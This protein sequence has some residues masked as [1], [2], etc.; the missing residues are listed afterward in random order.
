VSGPQPEQRNTLPRLGSQLSRLGVVAVLATLIGA[1][2]ATVENG[3]PGDRASATLSTQSANPTLSPFTT[4]PPPNSTGSPGD[5]T[6]N[7]PTGGAAGLAALGVAAESGQVVAITDGDTIKV[8]TKRGLLDVRVL[9]IDTPEVYFG[10]ECWGPE[11]SR[12]ARAIL[13]GKQVELRADLT[14]DRTDAYD[15]ALRYVILPNGDNYSVLAAE[16]GAARSYVYDAPVQAHPQILA[17]EHRARAADRGLWGG[18]NGQHRMAEPHSHPEPE[19]PAPEPQPAA[20]ANC[21]PGYDPCVPPPPPDLDCGDVNGPIRVSGED[22]HRLDGDD[23]GV[24]CE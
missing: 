23:D 5:E 12:F 17:A 22:P 7:R 19:P 11:A 20:A 10:A 4:S 18:C 6:D 3:R 15:R 21:A 2:S 16:A 14:Q 9:G 1:C 13:A 8:A 24:G